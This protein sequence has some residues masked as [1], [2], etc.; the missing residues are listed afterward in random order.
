MH[1]RDEAK[2]YFTEIRRIGKVTS[3]IEVCSPLIGDRLS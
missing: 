3:K 2:G 1:W